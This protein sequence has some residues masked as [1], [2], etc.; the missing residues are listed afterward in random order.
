MYK[1][2]TIKTNKEIHNTITK[3]Q[4]QYNIKTLSPKP[5]ISTINNMYQI[6]VTNNK[7]QITSNHNNK[8]KHPTN[9]SPSH[10]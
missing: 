7:H 3:H 10:L 4:N 9:T 1:Q 2:T 8:K 6:K 5:Q